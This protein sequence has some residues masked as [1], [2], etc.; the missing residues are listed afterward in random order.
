MRGQPAVKMDNKWEAEDALRTLIRAEEIKK[1]KD[2]MKRVETLA[3]K[4]QQ[5]A[6]KLGLLGKARMAAKMK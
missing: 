2:L 3:K 1:D 6:E 5:D 4:Q